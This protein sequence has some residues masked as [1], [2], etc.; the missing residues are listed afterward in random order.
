[1]FDG[2]QAVVSL[3][4]KLE[5]LLANPQAKTHIR[6]IQSRIKVYTQIPFLSNIS[7]RASRTNRMFSTVYD[8][9][10][11]KNFP[12]ISIKRR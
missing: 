12:L 5:H 11:G 9:S 4:G 1:M 7:R 2:D 6:L 3:F 8:I 10:S